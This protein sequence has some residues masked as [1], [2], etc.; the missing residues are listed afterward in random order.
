[1]LGVG[2][3]VATQKLLFAKVNKYEAQGYELVEN[4]AISVGSTGSL[5]NYVMLRRPKH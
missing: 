4:N 1:V 2:V 3:G 5:G